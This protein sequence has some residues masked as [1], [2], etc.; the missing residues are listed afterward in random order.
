LGDRALL[1]K[2]HTLEGTIR[3]APE[4]RSFGGTLSGTWATGPGSDLPILTIGGYYRP[5][6]NVE[7]S[8][9]LE[10][11]LSPYGKEDRVSVEPFITPGFRVLLKT[12]VTF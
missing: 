7:V 8:L 12:T 6:E 1:E 9:T 11:I 2:E 10:D 4:K 5:R 3:F